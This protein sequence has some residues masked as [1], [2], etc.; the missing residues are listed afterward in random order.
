MRPD[1]NGRP[2]L[3]A[4]YIMR[5]DQARGRPMTQSGAAVSQSRTPST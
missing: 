5:K 1:A 2:T 4:D 3:K